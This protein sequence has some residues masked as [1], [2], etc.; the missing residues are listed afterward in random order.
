[1]STAFSSSKLCW[2]CY[3]CRSEKGCYAAELDRRRAPASGA[4]GIQVERQHTATDVVVDPRGEVL[5]LRCGYMVRQQI[6][7]E[8][9]D[10]TVG[11][12]GEDQ[13]LPREVGRAAVERVVF[14]REVDRGRREAKGTT[15]RAAVCEIRRSATRAGKK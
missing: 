8:L 11:N 4:H 12:E 5:D 3:F 14:H 6:G 13:R 10:V 1:M 15:R 2:F 9:A 7:G